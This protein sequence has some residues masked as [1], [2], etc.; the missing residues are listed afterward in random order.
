MLPFTRI[1][2]QNI[3]YRT[4][5]AQHT[6]CY[7]IYLFYYI[8]AVTKRYKYNLNV[9]LTIQREPNINLKYRYIREYII[10]SEHT[11][12]GKRLLLYEME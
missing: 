8:T 9:N 5:M 10:C 12:K 11:T 3:N 4:C 7:I 2:D 1:V 6:L